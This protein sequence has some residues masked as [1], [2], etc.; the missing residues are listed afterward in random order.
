[1]SPIKKIV[2]R[3]VVRRRVALPAA[4]TVSALAT[5]LGITPVAVI[6]Q[7]IRHGVM[8]NI[9]QALDFTLASAIA[10]DF[11]YD[12][13][14]QEK[15]AEDATARAAGGAVPRP[16]VVTIMGHVDHGKTSLLDAIRR[17]NIVASEAGEITQHIG[18]YQVESEGRKITFLDTPGH[19]AFTA[20]RARGARITDIAVLV[21]AADDGVMPQTAEAVNHAKAAKVPIVVAINKTDKPGA[22]PEKVKRQL[23]DIG[24][25]V[26]E[27]GGDAVSTLVSAKKK[28]GISDLLESILLV[29]DIL[30]LKAEPDAPAQGVVVEAGMDKNRG[31]VATLLVHAGTLRV[32][33]YLVA[34]T[35]SGKV[36]AMFDDR[37]R[38]VKEAGPATP[39][40]VLGINGIPEAGDRFMS[41][42]EERQTQQMMAGKEFKSQPRPF[43]LT[44]LPTES[45]SQARQLNVILKTDVQG[46]IEP[47]R[48]SLDKLSMEKARV[49]ILHA[50]SGGITESDVM[51]ASAS[52]GIIV[53]FNAR[54]EPGTRQL[55][56]VEGVTIRSHNIIYSLVSD[57]E[58]ILKGIVPVTYVE[59]MVGQAEVKEVF[60]GG[61]KTKIAGIAVTE[62]KAVRDVMVRIIRKGEKVAEAKAT[63]LRHFKE[64]AKEVPTG[65]ECGA[66]LEKFH[67]FKVGD[68]L[69]FFVKE[70]A[71]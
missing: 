45:G 14:P 43:T 2:S 10:K 35:V 19:E 13:E 1:M 39:V 71:A 34:G 17:S 67:D 5:L 46:S 32:G 44:N 38:R 37:G 27:W 48:A 61:Q 25:V 28:Q 23:S 9:N 33:D 55:A 31:P 12:A 6:K 50:A 40:L 22:D 24:L 29:A 57:V 42:E 7:L 68:I 18:A 21:V 8:A 20:M 49:N 41:A 54:V 69:Q 56:G 60:P 65:S 62:G 53:G 11:S 16:P 15:K 64:D 66:K 26:E 47:I 30:E 70:K 3:K 51:L 4:V 63:S 52:Q 58:Q 36:K 59:V